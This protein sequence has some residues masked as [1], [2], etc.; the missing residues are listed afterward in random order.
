MKRSYLVAYLF[1]PLVWVLCGLVLDLRREGPTLE[2]VTSVLVGGYLFYA[3]PLLAWAVIA[4]V[5]KP[6]TWAWNAG[7]VAALCALGFTTGMSIWGPHDPSGLPYEWFLY[8]PLAGLMMAGVL[9]VWWLKGHRHA[10][11]R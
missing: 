9:A 4:A 3:A 7:F 1:V 11:V 2:A 5:V 10:G 6:V 8:W